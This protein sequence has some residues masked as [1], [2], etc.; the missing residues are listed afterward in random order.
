MSCA[1][2]EA[3]PEGLCP[4]MEL[5]LICKGFSQDGT[6]PDVAPF[7]VGGSARMPSDTFQS[8]IDAI[9]V[10]TSRRD[11]DSLSIGEELNSK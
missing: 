1:V 3:A 7:P 2:G 8:I 11:R 10:M 6:E 4:V 9:G 5:N